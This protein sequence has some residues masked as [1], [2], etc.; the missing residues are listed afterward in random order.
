MDF[1]K[2]YYFLSFTVPGLSTATNPIEAVQL[3]TVRHLG[4]LELTFRLL[5][6]SD[7]WN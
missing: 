4:L 1:T 2:N 6:I 7:D 5:D 3:Y